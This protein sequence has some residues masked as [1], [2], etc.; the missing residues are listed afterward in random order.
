MQSAAQRMTREEYL[1][2][3]ETSEIKHEFF[4]GE[5]FAMT[6]GTFEHSAIAVQIASLL[7]ARPSTKGCR[8]MNSDMRVRTPSGLDTYPDISVYC[9]EPHLTDNRLTLLN[10]VL[11]IEVISPNTSSYDRGDK[12]KLYRS[13]PTLKD[14]LLV[15]SQQMLVEHFRRTANEE[16]ILHVYQKPEETVAL[17]SIDD[18]LALADIYHGIQFAVPDEF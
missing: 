5:I 12:F 9:G 13:I 10:P 16:W 8:P 4:N 14:Y 3:E 17:G 11:I 15:D 1:A 7:N 6:G 18:S 2:F